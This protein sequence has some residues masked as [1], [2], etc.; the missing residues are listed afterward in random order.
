MLWEIAFNLWDGALLTAA[1]YFNFWFGTFV[2]VLCCCK[3]CLTQ[4]W[5]PLL[6]WN[7]HPL[8]GSDLVMSTHTK[9]VKK[10]CMDFSWEHFKSGHCCIQNK[11]CGCPGF[12]Q[13]LW[14]SWLQT[15]VVAILASNPCIDAHWNPSPVS[16]SPTYTHKTRYAFHQ[17]ACM[18]LYNFCQTNNHFSK[19]IATNLIRAALINLTPPKTS[20]CCMYFCQYV[21]ANMLLDSLFSLVCLLFY[22]QID[23]AVV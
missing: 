14:L 11:S 2:V 13:E 6:N 16:E 19:H 20:Q 18:T 22:L 17:C 9:L 15:R 23:D 4:F 3:F 5:E 10:L 8:Q 21:L 7:L 1:I 12:K